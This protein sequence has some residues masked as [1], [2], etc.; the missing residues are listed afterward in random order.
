MFFERAAL[1]ARRTR[2]AL[3]VLSVFVP[4]LFIEL[5]ADCRNIKCIGNWFKFIDE[6]QPRYI[7]L[8]LFFKS[9]IT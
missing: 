2:M 4:T 8:N 3:T 1:S 6:F 7:F 5:V 9:A